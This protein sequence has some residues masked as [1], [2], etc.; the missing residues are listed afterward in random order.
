MIRPF[1]A[2]RRESPTERGGEIW[3]RL[4][5]T[6][7]GYVALVAALGVV[8]LVLAASQVQERDVA[9]LA[10]LILLSVLASTAKIELPVPRGA[11]SLTVAYIVH[12]MALLL[13]G[14]PAAV[15]TA[16][17]GGWSQCTIWAKR[18]TP[19][20]QTLF[21]VA[22]LAIA[23]QATGAAN[24]WAGGTLNAI[25][26]LVAGSTAF[27]L[28]NTF[29][30]AGAIAL[31]TR[32]SLPH[33]WTRNF[34]TTWPGFLVGAGIAAAGAEGVTATAFWL[35]PIVLV[36][37]ALTYYAFK[38]HVRQLVDSTTDA[39]TG[40]GNLRFLHSHGAYELTRARQQ[41]RPLSIC[42]LDLDGFK[43]IND[44]L[45]HE[46]G[47]QVLR[48][49][50]RRLSDTV[51]SN[52]LSIRLGGDEF[53]VILPGARRAEVND[54]VQRIQVAIGGL[55][56][57]GVPTPRLRA[58]IGIA[59][60]P[61]DGDTLGQLLAVADERMYRNKAKRRRTRRRRRTERA[62]GKTRTETSGRGS[63]SGATSV[64]PTPERDA[65]HVDVWPSWPPIPSRPWPAPP[66]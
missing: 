23:V 14:T 63:V 60:Y 33:I 30:V 21:S 47:D 20:H 53:V 27:F 17:V 44:R 38:G 50:A 26:T 61:G 41:S 51:G 32:Q 6:A 45:G 2:F 66:R 54:L 18:P 36:L 57:D 31:A 65:T 55:D 22:A 29:L 1:A 12:Y 40:L 43:S 46:V 28:V 13:L 7:K 62:C 4:S 10:V 3:R 39:L 64:R 48:N 52:G 5:P 42:Y 34:A 19:V 15:L 49:V 25:G 8:T 16:A 35:I 37:A 56:V 9:R 24:D 58:S 59:E 11:S